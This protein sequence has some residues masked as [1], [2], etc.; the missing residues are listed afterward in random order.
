[1]VHV[2][3]LRNSAGSVGVKRRSSATRSCALRTGLK[4]ST[5]VRRTFGRLRQ[6]SVLSGTRISS[7]SSH[8]G[9]GPYS[10]PSA[11]GSGTSRTIVLRARYAPRSAIS[12]I[13]KKM[14]VVIRLLATAAK[15]RFM[16]V[17]HLTLKLEM[18]CALAVDNL[19]PRV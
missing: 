1:M 8:G 14:I 18:G 13:A 6:M 12:A 2:G 16:S 5:Y 10:S 9:I 7:R 15:N 4:M 11:Y 3:L 19:H 17:P